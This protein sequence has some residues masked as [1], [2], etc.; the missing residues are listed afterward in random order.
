MHYLTI[1]V[2]VGLSDI[3][4]IHMDAELVYNTNL[5]YNTFEECINDPHG[6][7]IVNNIQ[8]RLIAEGLSVK[9]SGDCIAL[10]D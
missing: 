10:E 1:I 6:A 7:F 4:P 8:N 5:F 9:V 2:L 3:A